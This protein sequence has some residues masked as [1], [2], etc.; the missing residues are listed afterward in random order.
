M[1]IEM[2]SGTLT[3]AQMR[4][5]IKSHNA[6]RYLDNVL[7]IEGKNP[8]ILG[9]E[10][11]DVTA[12]HSNIAIPYGRKIIKTVSGYM[13]KPGLI[14]VVSENEQYLE[15][16]HDVFWENDEDTKTAQ[17]GEQVSLQGVGYEVHYMDGRI[18]RF[19]R[20]P[21]AGVVVFESLD[22]EPVILAVMRTIKRTEERVGVEVYYADRVDYLHYDTSRWD[23]YGEG[24]KFVMDNSVPHEYEAVPV[25]VF[26]NNEEKVGDI[27]PAIGLIDAYD[28]LM[29]DSVNEFDRF[30]WAYLVLKGMGLNREDAE[31]VK[32]KR[33]FEILSEF[34]D[35]RFLTKDVPHEFIQFMAEWIR[36]EI[37]K[38]THVPDFTDDKVASGGMS[39]VAMD[40]MMYD[41]E[42]LCSVKEMY[43]KDGLY[44]R[45]E[46][47][48]TVMAKVGLPVGDLRDIDFIF[49]RNKIT[50]L[51][52]L[53]TAMQLYAGHV[54]ERTLLQSFAPFVTD[55][56]AEVDQV[57]E[58]KTANM[59]RFGAGLMG[60]AD[61]PEE[62]PADGE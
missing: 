43:F 48:N 33:V 17:I 56:D 52:D 4:E 15:A 2:V 28:R 12:P 54:S 45:V 37:H 5:A 16:L 14:Q 1:N 30:A 21:A 18:P 51:V 38:Q 27:E 25:A 3:D 49:N 62:S 42:T 10:F 60:G 11:K 50:S 31:E 24:I 22:L 23:M 34:G 53:G 47:L 61:E 46:L 41:F 26:Q 55:V 58:E 39:G 57:A 32:N 7:Y 20:I 19:T 29:S 13:F 36:K 44:R 59:E 9:R 8:T 35:V 6:K 40:R